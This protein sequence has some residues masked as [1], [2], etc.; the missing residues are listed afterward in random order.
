MAVRPVDS[1][2][3]LAGRS[4]GALDFGGA[5]ATPG[6]PCGDDDLLVVELDESACVQ[7]VE[8]G[9]AEGIQSASAIAV[10]DDTIALAGTFEEQLE[11]GGHPALFALPDTSAAFLL[12]MLP[13]SSPGQLPEG[14]LILQ[15]AD[16]GRFELELLAGEILLGGSV[17]GNVRVPV[18]H[19]PLGG[20]D[21]LFGRF[22]SDG[23][24]EHIEVAGGPGDDRSFLERRDDGVLRAYGTLTGDAF[25]GN[26]AVR[27][28]AESQD[29]F[30]AEL[31]DL[32]RPIWIELF[33][34]TED[35]R[36][37]AAGFDDRGIE[38]IGGDFEGT[39]S[40]GDEALAADG[41]D[42]WLVARDLPPPK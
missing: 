27:T 3:F 4:C 26:T 30:V 7:L 22:G 32:G 5:C 20:I 37:V 40:I 12:A 34:D 33:G 24:V 38:V 41:T 17:T 29:A 1:H 13:P 39:V 9:S 42:V 15:I 25:V 31:D 2:V 35:Q 19:G 21:G 23:A 14:S 6:E 36:L 10:D 16:D 28:S 8:L 11:V 18:S